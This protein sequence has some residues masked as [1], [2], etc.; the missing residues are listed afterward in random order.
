M[1]EWIIKV[2]S[3]TGYLA[4]FLLMVLENVFPPIPSEL[5]MPLAGYMVTKGEFSFIGVIV[6]GTVGSLVGTLPLYYLGAA[7]GEGRLRQ[8]VARY[9]RWITV[10]CQDIDR[11]KRWFERHGA[12]AVFVCRFVPGV[13]SLISIPAGLDRMRLLPFLFYSGAGLGVWTALL[14]ALGYILGRSFRRVEDYL[15]PV[16]YVILGGILLLYIWR[17]VRHKGQDAEKGMRAGREG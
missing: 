9:G 4:L 16:S 2:L 8:L 12:L 17:V 5:I 1:A 13:R 14:A 15:N 6:A 11:A 7:F 3:S 10:S